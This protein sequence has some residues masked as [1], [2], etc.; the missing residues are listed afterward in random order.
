MNT[1]EMVIKIFKNWIIVQ[2]K[3]KQIVEKLKQSNL[4]KIGKNTKY[5]KNGTSKI[6]EVNSAQW[7]CA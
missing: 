5:I 2:K 6:A 3:K 1:V 4:W 7:I